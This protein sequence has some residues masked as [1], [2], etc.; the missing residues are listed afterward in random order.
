MSNIKINQ[1][2]IKRYLENAQR[3][4]TFNKKAEAIESTIEDSLLNEMNGDALNAVQSMAQQTQGKKPQFEYAYNQLATKQEDQEDEHSECD[5]DDLRALGIDEDTPTDA[6]IEAE[7]ECEECEDCDGCEECDRE[8]TEEEK[9]EEADKELQAMLSK[10]EHDESIKMTNESVFDRLYSQATGNI[11]VVEDKGKAIFESI[12]H[13]AEDVEEDTD[14]E[15][16]A[17]DVEEDTDEEHDAEDYENEECDT[18]HEDAEHEE[19]DDIDNEMDE[20]VS[21]YFEQ[22]ETV[23]EALE[24]IAKLI[25]YAREKGEHEL[26]AELKAALKRAKAEIIANM[27][28]EDGESIPRYSKE[29]KIKTDKMQSALKKMAEMLNEGSMTNQQTHND[30]AAI[31]VEST[32]RFI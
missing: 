22:S 11:A 28:A 7:Q 13:D 20:K 1:E 4:A 21:E 3:N 30:L 16:D 31:Y 2:S 32:K 12:L 26:E 18:E 15:H 6:E 23:D 10:H 24:K 25:E 9:E 5:E 19:H 17:E 29:A 8:K 14:E 27:S